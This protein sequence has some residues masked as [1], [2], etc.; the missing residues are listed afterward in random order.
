MHLLLLLLRHIPFIS[1]NRLVFQTVW[2]NTDVYLSG[3]D[4]AFNDWFEANEMCKDYYN[5]DRI[6]KWGA[7]LI[8][9]IES[10]NLN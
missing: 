6:E 4:I 3:E 1:Q 7:I 2:H 10:I 9:P 8:S 5:R